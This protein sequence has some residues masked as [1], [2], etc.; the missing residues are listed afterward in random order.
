MPSMMLGDELKQSGYLLKDKKRMLLKNAAKE[1]KE[2]TNG[3]TNRKLH[4]E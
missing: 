4:T 1:K 3:C 2:C